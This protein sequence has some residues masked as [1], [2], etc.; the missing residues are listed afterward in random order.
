MTRSAAQQHPVTEP[1]C[2]EP[3]ARDLIQSE[4]LAAIVRD[5]DGA[6]H[7]HTNHHL[8][9]ARATWGMFWDGRRWAPPCCM[10][11]KRSP[12]T[13]GDPT[14]LVYTVYGNPTATIREG[15]QT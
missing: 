5:K 8:V 11:G 12:G 13:T 6:Y 15:E 14:L 1:L 7:V 10:P 4:A 3:W 9:G 2:Q